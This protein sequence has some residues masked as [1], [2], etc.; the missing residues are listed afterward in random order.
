MTID[1]QYLYTDRYLSADLLEV[2]R[3]QSIIVS[4]DADVWE[5]IAA[6]NNAPC[7]TASADLPSPLP[8]EADR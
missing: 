3:D 1:K 5:R 4:Q 6:W 2:L 7:D 8:K